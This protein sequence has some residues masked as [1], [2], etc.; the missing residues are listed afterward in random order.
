[1]VSSFV[2]CEGGFHVLIVVIRDGEEETK[3]VEG[4]SRARSGWVICGKTVI[5]LRE[6]LA[7][8][9]SIAAE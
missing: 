3:L 5:L 7:K 1:M 4:F 6:V 8:I 2:G 9:A